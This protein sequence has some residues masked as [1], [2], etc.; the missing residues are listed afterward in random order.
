[1]PKGPVVWALFLL[2]QEIGTMRK[3]DAFT[4]CLS[5]LL[6]ISLGMN[7]VQSRKIREFQAEY[8][9]KLQKRSVQPGTVVPSIAATEVKG[10]ATVIRYSDSKLPTVL[11]MFAPKCSWCQRN[12]AAVRSLSEQ[13]KDKARV[14]GVSVATMGTD[15]YLDQHPLGFQAIKDV[16][17]D[18][19]DAFKMGSTPQ[20]VVVSPEGKVLKSW[21]GAYMGNTKLEVESYFGVRLPDVDESVHTASVIH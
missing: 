9:A 16:A 13:L 5:A 11:Y 3:F 10:G 17:T 19:H 7:I 20:T 21:V 18:A 6:C 12:R 15:E 14:V 1:M 4:L 2:R 8:E